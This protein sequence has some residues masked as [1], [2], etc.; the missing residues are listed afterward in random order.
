MA[1][2][3]TQQAFEL[4]KKSKGILIAFKS[5]WSGDAIASALA[6]GQ[7]LTKFDKQVDIV[8][9]GLSKK[10]GNLDFLPIEQIKSKLE[11]LQKLVISI[12]TS[13]AQV[14]EFYYDHGKDSLNIYISPQGGKF[15]IKDIT[16]TQSDYKYDLIITVDTPD[17]ESLGKMFDDNN[18]FFHTTP[19]INIDHSQHNEYFGNVNIVDLTA[20]STT[21]II[22]DVIKEFDQKLLDEDINTYILG[23]I[24]IATKNFKLPNITPKTLSTASKLIK[25][26]ARREEIIQ[27]LYQNRFIST[28]KLWGRVL[29]RLNNDMDDKLVWSSISA[30]DFLE[31]STSPS[32]I[33]DV[34]DELIVSMPKTEIIVLL[35]EIQSN[36]HSSIKCIVYSVKN[37]NSLSIS[38]KFD[39]RGN[40]EIAKFSLSDISLIEAERMVVGE[41]KEKLS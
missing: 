19:K 30:Q 12:K 15:D 18:D 10:P 25:A 37:I 39:P 21:E 1:L 34:I 4:I 2:T 31:T 36:S 32:E 5:D 11:N 40:R 13:K 6:L 29:S 41:I 3:N 16:T 20:A 7:I 38:K 22:Y 8:C 24:I 26:G 9:S 14:G 23:G 33:I 17:I 28:L 27:H 35:Y